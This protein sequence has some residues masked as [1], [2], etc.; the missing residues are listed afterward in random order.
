MGLCA[1][2][3]FKALWRWLQ[4]IETEWKEDILSLHTDKERREVLIQA[5]AMLIEEVLSIP[6]TAK[7]KS[8]KREQQER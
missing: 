3:R 5:R 2:D 7:N 1:D 4:K 8:D 6:E